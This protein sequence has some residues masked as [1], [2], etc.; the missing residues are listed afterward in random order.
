[1][2]TVSSYWAAG[3]RRYEPAVNFD[4]RLYGSDTAMP[5]IY[6]GV[7][8]LALLGREPNTT[9]SDG[10]LHV[11][12]YRPLQ[13]ELMTGSLDVPG[14]SYALAVSPSAIAF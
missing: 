14:K 3:F 4:I 8:D 1:M 7:G 11:L 12:N 10:F 2:S 6:T 5:A 13:L 9:D